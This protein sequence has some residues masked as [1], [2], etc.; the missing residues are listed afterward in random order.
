ME[1]NEQYQ[2]LMK[3]VDKFL[4]QSCMIENCYNIKNKK[5]ALQCHDTQSIFTGIELYVVMLNYVE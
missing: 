5:S 2:K 1:I 3:N 4:F